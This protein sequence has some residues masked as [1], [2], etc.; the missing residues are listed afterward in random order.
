MAAMPK[1]DLVR[2]MELLGCDFSLMF[3]QTEMGPVAT[4]FRPEHQL[5]HEGAVGTPTVNVRVGIMDAEG[6]LLP[7]GETGEIVYRS[8]QVLTSY[9]DNPEATAAVFEHGWFHS[10]DAGHFGD[11]GMLWFDDRFKDVIKSGGE[12]VSSIEVEKA[13]L[14]ADRRIAE[15]AV[16][17]LPHARWTEAITAFVVP[18]PGAQVEVER[19][20]GELRQR[21]SAFKCPKDIVV[22]EVLPKTATGKVQKAL[23][24]KLHANHYDKAD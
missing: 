2:A 18:A 16:V 7:P 19:L 21:L 3:G 13:L 10:G 14:E 8:P 1:G 9:L 24:R 20:A 15:V 5:S 22:R 6:H 23:L 17:G 11:D 12:N 4:F